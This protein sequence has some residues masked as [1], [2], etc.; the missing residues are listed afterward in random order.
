MRSSRFERALII[1][2]AVA[3]AGFASDALTFAATGSSLVLGR[4][5]S[6]NATTVIQNTRTGAALKLITKSSSSSPLAVNGKGK[7]TNLYADRAAR[8]DD[9][10]KLGGRTPGQVRA[11]ATGPSFGRT[12]VSDSIVDSSGEAGTSVSMTIGVDGMPWLAYNGVTSGGAKLAHCFSPDCSTAGTGL[13]WTIDSLSTRGTSIAIGAD[14]SPMVVSYDHVASGSDLLNFARCNNAQCNVRGGQLI[15]NTSIDVGAFPSLTEGR[16]GLPIISYH[17]TT[18]GDLKV[19]HCS[20]AMCGAITRTALDTA[21]D[22]GWFTSITIG[23]DGLPIISYYD[24]TNGNLKVAHCSN[25][26]CTASTKT[27]I[28]SSGDVGWYTSIGIGS[29]G[30]AA[31]AYYDAIGKNLKMAHCSN[32]ACTSATRSVVDGS[33]HDAGYSAAL[34]I[35]PDGLPWI[36]YEDGTSQNAMLAHCTTATCSASVRIVV[37]HSGPVGQPTA[38]AI[39]ADGQPLVAY[40][41]DS[42]KELHMAKVAHSAWSPNGWGR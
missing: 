11:D 14:G 28:D 31:I 17:D 13:L 4:T 10:A 6:A 7:V 39:G 19:A 8:A 41:N 25:V 29:D 30:L 22:V 2:G 18:K 40:Y 26:A 33:A 21:G 27:T 24:V 1:V 5:N 37:G 15:D 38:I 12:I 32:A 20:N 34:I 35:G 23:T 3:I 36:S 16:D 9:A 42:L